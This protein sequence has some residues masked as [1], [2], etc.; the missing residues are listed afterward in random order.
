MSDT[1]HPEGIADHHFASALGRI[2]QLIAKPFFDQHGADL[3]GFIQADNKG[4]MCRI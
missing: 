1:R 2:R 3:L 4:F